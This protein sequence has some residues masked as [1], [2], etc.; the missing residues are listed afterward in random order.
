MA[1]RCRGDTCSTAVVP[2]GA[3]LPNIAST[4]GL[5]RGLAATFGYD[6]VTGVG[7]P[8]SAYFASFHSR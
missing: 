1:L 7:I 8:A 5:D 3:Q 6:A 2:A 4:F